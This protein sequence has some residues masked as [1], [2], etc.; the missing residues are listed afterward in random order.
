MAL[1]SSALP[2]SSF[3][4]GQDLETSA[5]DDD[6]NKKDTRKML[7]CGKCGMPRYAP[8]NGNN[9]WDYDGI[10]MVDLNFCRRTHGTTR[11][12]RT[13]GT[14]KTKATVAWLDFAVIQ[15]LV[16]TSK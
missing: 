6:W 15:T 7:S 2:A 14:L 16:F 10:V 13:I 5:G 4:I 11:I 9:K 3:S 1:G 12:R 8:K